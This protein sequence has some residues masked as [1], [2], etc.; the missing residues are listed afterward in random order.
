MIDNSPDLSDVAVVVVAWRSE[1]LLR[2][3]VGH[4]RARYPDVTVI[5]VKTGGA[6]ADVPEAHLTI[7]G[8]NRGYAGGNN[9]GI[10]A[11]LQRGA[12]VITV[13]NSDTFP[14]EGCLEEMR[15]HLMA[16]T[17]TVVVG[18]ALHS[19]DTR[20]R[21]EINVG[22]RVDW[23]TGRTSPSGDDAHLDFP[24]GALLMFRSS[25]LEQIGGFDAGLFLFSEEIDW[26]ERARAKGF[27]VAV[28]PAARAIHLGSVT[29][30]RAPKA[31]AYYGF[32]NSIIVRRRYGMAH[33]AKVTTRGETRRAVRVIAGHLYHR[34]FRLIWPIVVALREGLGAALPV[35]DD[36]EAA[37]AQQVWET[38]DDIK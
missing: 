38:R 26:C 25:A 34:R 24:C 2:A 21:Q 7:S 18:A 1:G 30:A 9:L 10:R 20:G 29:V 12:R 5:V 37:L 13:A 15:R 6:P 31:A 4:L 22:T 14:E 35:N 32:R 33:G 36:P 3:C 28:A 11:A 8:P 17:T 23:M 16:D 19:W 27:T